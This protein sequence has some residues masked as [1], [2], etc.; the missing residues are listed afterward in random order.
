MHFVYRVCTPVVF[1]AL[2][3]GECGATGQISCANIN[4]ESKTWDASRIISGSSILLEENDE[5]YPSI[6]YFYQPSGLACKKEI[7]ARYEIEGGAPVVEHIFFM[8]LNG[9]PNVFS[10]VS[11]RINS[12]GLGT[13]GL[14]YQV[15]AYKLNKAGHLIENTRVSHSS[16]M[17]G[18]YGHWDGVESN[19]NYRT[20]S[21][22]MRYWRHK[23]PANR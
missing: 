7:F 2:L 4:F 15:Y 22:V 23:K 17:N 16:E 11:W 14:W 9:A 21:N 13:F 18:M 1:L 12:R 6:L 3:T 19:F 8:N 20:P 10:I 5:K